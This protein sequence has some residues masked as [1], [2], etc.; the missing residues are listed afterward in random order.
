MGE[1]K[2]WQQVT[3][4]VP[5]VGDFLTI[6]LFRPHWASLSVDKDADPE[7]PHWAQPPAVSANTD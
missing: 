5:N 1:S 6:Q 2:K 3:R 7:L 4:G